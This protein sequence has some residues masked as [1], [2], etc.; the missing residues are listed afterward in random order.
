MKKYRSIPWK[1]VEEEAFRRGLVAPRKK[2]I[3]PC[4]A[5]ANEAIAT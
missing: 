1:T 3:K 2:L 5:G 4:T